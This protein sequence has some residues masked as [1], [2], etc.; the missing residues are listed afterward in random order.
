MNSKIIYRGLVAL[1]IISILWTILNRFLLDPGAADFL[2]Q[3]SG[4]KRTIN[5]PVWI[6]V[7]DIHIVFASI[8]LLTGAMNFSNRV[9]QHYRMLHR[10]AG[11]VYLLS[12]LIVL[13]TSGYMA[14]YATGGKFVS[15]MFNLWNIAWFIVTSIA[16]ISI[17]RKNIVGHRKWMIRSYAF[18]FTN[19]AIHLFMILFLDML[20]MAYSAAYSYSVFSSILVLLLLAEAVIKSFKIP[21][22]ST[23][24]IIK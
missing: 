2:L 20:H 14:P 22:N 16:F 11:Y 17:K 12:V 15:V 5:V 23:K 8:A 10:M 9:L 4:L 1:A 7:L 24:G 6:T 19:L 21:M 18:C 3:K 13:L